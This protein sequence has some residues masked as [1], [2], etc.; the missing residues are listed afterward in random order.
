MEVNYLQ[1]KGAN[2]KLAFWLIT[3]PQQVIPEYSAAL[4]AVA[5]RTFPS[6]KEIVGECYFKVE[7]IPVLDSLR[8]VPYGFLG[9]LVKGKSIS[10]QF[11][12][13]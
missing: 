3:N 7:G 2:D 12:E 11:E 4:Y 5:G 13:L 1:F 6:Y 9:Q 8:K 10:M